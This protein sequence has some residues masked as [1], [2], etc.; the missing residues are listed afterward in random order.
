M[1]RILVGST[2]AAKVEG[3]RLALEAAAEVD[4]RFARVI[5]E[6]RDL[7]DI[8]PR[9]PMSIDEVIAGAR[10]RAEALAGDV[11]GGR[12]FAVGVEG[13]LHRVAAAGGGWSLQSWAAVTDGESWGYGAGPALVLPEAI[14]ERVVAGEELGDV[15][16]RLA[17]GEVRGTRGAWGVLTRDAI[18]RRD[19]FRLA[20]LAAF[21]RFYN[22]ARWR[23]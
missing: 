18:D 7:T 13:G 21:A 17:E 4:P 2:R 16:D 23:G 3:T 9:M 8:A 19:A 11:T 10:T 20:V 15:I 6:P 5:L 22:A 14:A 12:G 1:I